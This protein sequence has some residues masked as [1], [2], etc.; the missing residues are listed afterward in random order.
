[1]TKS[2][3][4]AIV[5]DDSQQARK[6][7][8]LM[9]AEVAPQ[10]EVCAEAENLDEAVLL[11]REHQPS[12][13]FLDIE[14]PGKSGLQLLEELGQVDFIFEII[15]TTAYNQFA[16]NAFRL[17]AIDYLLKPI[18]EK[19]LKEAVE[20][21]IKKLHWQSLDNQLD[22]LKNNLE[23][24]SSKII[25]IPTSKGIELINVHE[26]ICIEADGSYAHLSLTS[27]RKITIS[28]NLRFFENAFQG[29]DFMLRP[30]RSF[31]INMHQIKR[32]DKTDRGH[33]VMCNDAEIDLARDKR[34]LFF[35]AVQSLNI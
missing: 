7:L 33:I 20:R 26:I 34:S 2:D 1:M 12:L 14:M 29:L 4:K 32:F 19:Q 28:K 3:I 5:I 24:S 11:M 22:V 17:S 31:I 27:N 13:V 25:R 15:F 6:L 23:S 8:R 21:A 30:H 35:N 18:D 16:I 10:I 9:L